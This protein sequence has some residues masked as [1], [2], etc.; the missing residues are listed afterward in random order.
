MDRA[1]PRAPWLRRLP[2]GVWTAVSWCA[3]AL[4]AL[5]LFGSTTYQVAL[6]GPRGAFFTAL[7]QRGAMAVL[8]ALPVGWVRRWPVPVFGVIAAESV[9]V[10]V[11]GEHT[12]PLYVA[13]A[14]LVGCLA[15]ARPRRTALT[16]AGGTLALSLAQWAAGSHHGETLG[17]A[18]STVLG[19]AA[20]VALP[21]TIGNSV[22]QQRRYGEALREY[23]ADRAVAEERLRIARELHDMVA[24]SIGV[25]AIQSGAA[26]L[27]LDTQPER[28]R[29]ALTAIESTSRE[30]LAG[31]RRMLVS[32]RQAEAEAPAEGLE[33]VGRLVERAAGAGLQV[34]VEWRGRRRPLPPEIDLAAFRIIQESVTNAVRHSGGRRCRVSV[35]YGTEAVAIEVVD[36]GRGGTPRGPGFGISGMRER[37]ALLNGQFSAGV[38]PDG[39]FQVAARI[40]V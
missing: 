7:W 3:A 30:T 32:L 36:D 16:A 15:A 38:R 33:G 40:P 25:I 21:W 27:V 26:G 39:G 10:F 2:S 8:L 5:L 4:F 31:L 35:E 20:T 34:E 28:V 29:Q 23:A 18:V 37:A 14:C 12:W 22:R 9:L 6:H 17:D 11:L 24:H 13:M 19:M 1:L